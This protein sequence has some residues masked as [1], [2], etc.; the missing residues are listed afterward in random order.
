MNP[1]SSSKTIE[2]VMQRYPRHEVIRFC[3][4]LTGV[5]ELLLAVFERLALHATRADYASGND[6][7][8]GVPLLNT[9][10]TVHCVNSFLVGYI[11]LLYDQT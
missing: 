4:A 11:D 7:P 9:S 2:D 1:H 8:P 6:H 10:L 3:L 5:G